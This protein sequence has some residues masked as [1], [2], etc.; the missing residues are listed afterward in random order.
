MNRR[1]FLGVFGA[2]SAGFAGAGLIKSA[3]SVIP[4]KPDEKPEFSGPRCPG[5]GGAMSDP[6]F[7]D[8][9]GQKGLHDP[10]CSYL[11][12]RP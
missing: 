3:G 11:R 9:R 4:A 8:D 6:Q 10:Y 2:A 7:T 12:R 5:C 1:G